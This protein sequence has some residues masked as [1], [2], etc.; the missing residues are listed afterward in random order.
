M[1]AA[2]TLMTSSP[3]ASAI[4]LRLRGNI[5]G[6]GAGGAPRPSGAGSTRQPGA[7][8]SPPGCGGWAE[9]EPAG[10]GAGMLLL[11]QP[12]EGGLEARV[13][14]RRRVHADDIDAL[15]RR[16][17]GDGAEHGQPVVAVRGD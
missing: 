12:R 5:G 14:A 7:R 6:F 8:P 3:S 15:A 9:G 13:A 4:H 2:M 10:A 16:Q 1:N 17:A 11:Q